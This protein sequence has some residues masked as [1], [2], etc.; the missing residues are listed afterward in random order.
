MR[1]VIPERVQ[2]HAGHEGL[3]AGAEERPGGS[4]RGHVQ[5][6]D[7]ATSVELCG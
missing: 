7:H 3:L 4:S 2:D 6:D 5:R 1:H